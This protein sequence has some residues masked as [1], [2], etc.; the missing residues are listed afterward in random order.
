MDFISLFASLKFIKPEITISITLLLVVIFDIIFNENKK[1]V[2]LITL[3]GVFIALIFTSLNLLVEGYAFSPVDGSHNFGLLTLD[4]FGSFFKVIVLVSTLLIL[5][6]SNNSNEIINTGKRQ[7]EYYALMLGMLLGMLFMTSASDLIMVYLSMEL[8]SLSSY[9]LAGFLKLRDR[10]S[11]A[12]LKYLLYGAVSSA[13]MLFGISLIYGL[14]GT[15]NLYLI[16]LYLQA[17]QINYIPFALASIMIFAGIGFK[18]SS[19]PFHFWTPDVY[20]GAPV[21][22]TAFL[23]VA[24]KAAGF[25]LFIRLLKTG[26]VLRSNE[27]GMW[28]LSDIFDWHSLLIFVSILTMTLG[29]FSALW[30]NNL[31]RMLAYSSIAHAGYML[32]GVAVLSSQGVVAVLIY[33]FFYMLMNIG[34]FFVVSIIADKY[35]SEDIHDYDSLGYK[36]PWLAAAFS[37]FL[38]SLTGLPPTAGFIGKL[39]IFIALVDSNMIAVAVIALLNTVVSLYYY[40]RVMKHMYL[41]KP[42]ENTETFSTS[43]SNLVYLILLSASVLLLGIYFS[44]VVNLAKQCVGILGL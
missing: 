3:F 33:F 8:L 14:T 32:L 35:N 39:Y 36:N 18:I 24:S 17:P 12:S 42:A 1:I 13:F 15:T 41:V 43:P 34:A 38:I 30:Q 44:P 16:N 9:V 11:E 22:I 40:I 2:W 26:F 10:D 28:I 20:E 6:F 19:A 31:K 4:S 37:I 7:G 25:A 29:N 27:Q 5:Y 23:S 21:A